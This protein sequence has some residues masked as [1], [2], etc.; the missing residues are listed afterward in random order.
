MLKKNWRLL[1][2][3]MMTLWKKVL[4]TI[5]VLDYWFSLPFII[6]F[7]C[8]EPK[9]KKAGKK[10]KNA[11]EESDEDVDDEKEKKTKGKKDKKKVSYVIIF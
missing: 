7:F 9:A 5:T 11:K 2:Q 1:P 8:A 4:V 3:A 10:K 6:H